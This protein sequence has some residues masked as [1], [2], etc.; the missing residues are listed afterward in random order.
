MV[1][2]APT[3]GGVRALVVIA[4]SRINLSFAGVAIRVAVG[5]LKTATAGPVQTPQKPA[6]AANAL[7]GSYINGAPSVSR[8]AL[9][10]S[11]A[12]QSQ[13]ELANTGLSWS[14]VNGSSTLAAS[15]VSVTDPASATYLTLCTKALAR[16]KGPMAK[17]FVKEA[18]RKLWPGRAFSLELGAELAVELERHIEDPTDR[19]AFR[20][21][22]KS[23]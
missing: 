2:G 19:I 10:E 3:P 13:L 23:A 4:E 9:A 1:N 21:A 7:A 18:I 8:A 14:G 12:S 22:L 6:L 15:G 5:K 16:C 11:Q 20:K 17:A